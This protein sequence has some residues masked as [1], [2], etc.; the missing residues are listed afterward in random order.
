MTDEL[1][2]CVRTARVQEFN[3]IFRLVVSTSIQVNHT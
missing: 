1:G 2:T 3:L